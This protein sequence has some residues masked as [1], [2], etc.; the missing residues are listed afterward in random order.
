MRTRSPRHAAA[1]S[2]FSERRARLLAL[3]SAW[4]ACFVFVGSSDLSAADGEHSLALRVGKVWTLAGDP[5]VDATIV[6]VDGKIQTVAKDAEIPEGLRVLDLPHHVAIP[7][8]IDAETNLA[9][10][11]RDTLRSIAPDVLAIDGWDFFADRD[12]L[13][14]GGVTT[15]YVAPGIARGGAARLISGRGAVVKTG[16]RRSDPRARIVD[17]SL[18]LQVTLGD[19]AGQQPAV[20]RPPVNANPDNPFV[21]IQPP[22]PQSRPG[23]FLALRRFFAQARELSG[24]ATALTSTAT[25]VPVELAVVQPVLSRDDHLRVRAGKARD[26]FQALTFAREEGLRLVIEGGAEAEKLAPWLKEMDV[27]VVLPGILRPG[28]L[29]AGDIVSPAREGR[30]DELSVQRL[31]E[32]GVRVVLHSPS[33]RESD[34]L[35]LEAARVVGLGVPPEKALRLVTHEAARALGIE[36]RVGSIAPGKDADIVLL[37]GEPFTPQGRPQAVLIEGEV[38][39]RRP[40]RLPEACTLIRCG[41][42][43]TGLGE[44]IVGG[45]IALRDGKIEYVGRHLFLSSEDDFARVVDATGTTVIPGL[46]DAGGTAGLRAE[47]LSPGFGAAP[48]A[49]GAARGSKLR[50]VDS[51]DP[52]DPALFE[53]VRA[54]ITTAVIV[55]PPTRGAS[56]QV[57]VLKLRAADPKKAV[58]EDYAAMYFGGASSRTLKQAKEY[59]EAWTKYEAAKAKFDAKPGK[60]DASKAPKPPS[61][62]E[63][64]NAYRPLFR[65]DVPA[66]VEASNRSSLESLT[67]LL[68]GE[69]KMRVVATGLGSITRRGD[70]DRV[71]DVLRKQSEGV[72][73]HAPLLRSERGVSER[74][75]DVNWPREFSAR[76]LVPG[77]RSRVAS[78]ARLLPLEVAQAVREGWSAAQ[79]VQAMSSVPARIFSVDERVGAI[80]KGRDADLVF[81]EGDPFRLTSR[82]V[83]VWVDGR[84]VH[85]V[86]KLAVREIA[87]GD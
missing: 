19:L 85:E 74:G 76:G 69:Y 10:D 75:V 32:R 56:G 47:Q 62:S 84:P 54:G 59:H 1:S 29:P 41:R 53:L 33:D 3:L 60:K 31:I 28:E 7:G 11:S 68:G 73:L 46:I 83:A 24:A 58:L 65:R 20:Y 18:G 77:L 39:E 61:V 26:I 45:S 66:L 8:L 13:L 14:A 71:V 9:S 5:I 64:Q 27:P 35:L 79:A 4:A 21:V 87:E 51:I 44:E 63:T 30:I 16:G 50:L 36:G 48:G 12:D 40:P 42:I 80:E 6:I 70:F 15:V 22:L 2:H 55:P 82:V 52:D 86:V 57:A 81:I 34:D 37:G 38:L 67:Q 17:Q 49:S 23:E 43:L 72:I 25:P 78:G